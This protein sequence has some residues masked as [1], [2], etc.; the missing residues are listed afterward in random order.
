MLPDTPGDWKQLA[1][2]ASAEMNSEK[3]L[4]LVNELNQVLGEREDKLH[5]QRHRENQL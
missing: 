4:E 2:K 1:E 5:Q 3:L